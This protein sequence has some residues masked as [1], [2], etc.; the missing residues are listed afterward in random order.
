MNKRWQEHISESMRMSPLPLHCAMRKYGNHNFTIKVIDECDERLLNERE[1]YWTDQYNAVEECYVHNTTLVKN[2]PP[3]VVEEVK[4]EEKREPWGFMLK[5]NRGDGKHSRIRVLGINV[6]TGE[7]K[8]WE[9][10]TAAALELT[11]DRKSNA[12]I[13]MAAAN[14]TK[15]YGYRWKRLDNKTNKTPIKGVHKRTWNEIHFDSIIE[16][17]R[18]FGTNNTSGIR[19]SLL[20][21]HRYSYKRYYWFYD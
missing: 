8:I 12:V 16:A 3:K 7:E 18:Y 13:N 20:N 9:S 19:Q 21:P 10:F 4:E 2:E 5:E 1:K 14:G 11:G 15:A 17:C 6:E